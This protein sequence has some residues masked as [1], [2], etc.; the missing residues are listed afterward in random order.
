MV[1]GYKITNLDNYVGKKITQEQL[2][3]ILGY[4]G[5]QKKPIMYKVTTNAKTV[6]RTYNT[7]IDTFE[8]SYRL[9][10]QVICNTSNQLDTLFYTSYICVDFNAQNDDTYLVSIGEL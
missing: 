2:Y 3:D 6:Y 4:V 5:E 10:L 8:D 1:G 7:V 9:Y